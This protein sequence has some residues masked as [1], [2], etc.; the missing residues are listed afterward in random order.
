[1]SCRCKNSVRN[2]YSH[3]CT[4]ALRDKARHLQGNI[5]HVLLQNSEQVVNC[6]EMLWDDLHYSS[7]LMTLVKAHK[8]STLWIFKVAEL[9]GA[10]LP[11]TDV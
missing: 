1:M 10:T 7:Q 11:S 3:T 8:T 6:A 2:H 5:R 9:L 4:I